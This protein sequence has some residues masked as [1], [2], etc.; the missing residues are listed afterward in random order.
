MLT[1]QMVRATKQLLRNVL[2]APSMNI[3]L[4]SISHIAQADSTVIFLGT[5]YH[6]YNEKREQLE[7]V[8]V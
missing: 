7:K 2:Y 5:T 3:T 6:I 8:E 4:V 1:F